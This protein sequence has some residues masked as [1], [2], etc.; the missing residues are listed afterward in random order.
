M[1]VNVRTVA[2]TDATSETHRA[3]C[4][5]NHTSDVAFVSIRVI[6]VN[7]TLLSVFLNARF[8][9][10]DRVVVAMGHC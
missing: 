1:N 5:V 3:R 10:H 2:A 4:L 7:T 9:E 6:G 8:V